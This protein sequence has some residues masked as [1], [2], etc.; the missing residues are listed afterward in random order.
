MAGETDLGVMLAGLTAS[1]RPG[2]FTLVS[3]PEAPPIGDGVEAVL[4]EDEGITVVATVAR[5]RTERWPVRFEAAWLTLDVHSAL[6]AV[7]LTAAVSAA[8]AEEDI[9]ANVLAGHFHDHLLVPIDR[10]DDALACLTRLAEHSR[11]S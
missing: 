4:V 9:P 11:H 6:E 8:L 3:L 7:G 10:A 1:V 5:A 2:T